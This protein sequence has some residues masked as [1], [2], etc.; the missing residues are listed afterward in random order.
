MKRCPECRR[1]YYD[2]S[3]LYCLDDGS[4]LLEGPAAAD[5]L[6]SEAPTRQLNNISAGPDHVA[7]TNTRDVSHRSGVGIFSTSVALAAILLVSAAAGYYFYHRASRP[8]FE[9]S[10]RQPGTPA[11]DYYLRGKLDSSSENDQ[12]NA[13]AIKILEDVVKSDSTFAPA[14]AELARAYSIRANDWAPDGDKSKLFD[15]ARIAVEKSLALDPNLALGHAVRAYVMWTTAGRFPHEQA[16]QSLKRATELDPNLAV[17]H[18]QLG[19]IYLHIG[20]FD[21]ARDESQKAIDIDPTDSSARLRL[22]LVEQYNTEYAKALMIFNTVPADTNPAIVVRAMASVMF[23]LGR[24]GEAEKIV[25]EFLA[26]NPDEGGN[27]TSVKAMLLAKAGRAGDA[28]A[29][30]RRALEIGKGYQHF[31]HT[32]YNVACA[33]AILDKREEAIN[34]LRVTADEGFPCYPLFEKDRNLDNLRDDPRFIEM[35]AGMKLQWEHYKADL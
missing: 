13:N 16:V 34:W 1:D 21:K 7:I 27:V 12:R 15:E 5:D 35:M 24:T 11:Y 23:Q 14:Y 26:A 3:L 33:Y 19:L 8:Q 29:A 9:G 10:F 2:D 18:Q 17:A 4:A 30:I 31:H 20:L 22:G 28:E 25:Q 32:T 6:G